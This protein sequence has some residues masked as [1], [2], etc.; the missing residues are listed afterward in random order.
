MDAFKM[1]A[2]LVCVH[3]GSALMQKGVG[4]DGKTFYRP[5][6]GHIKLFEKSKNALM[7]EV[8]EEIH[9]ATRNVRLL[10]VVENIFTY[11]GKKAHEIV[12]LYYG[13]LAKKSLY[14]KRILERDEDGVKTFAYWIP[15]SDLEKAKSRVY[16]EGTYEQILKIASKR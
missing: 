9:T 10:G 4:D 1:K 8:N 6:G 3:N 16:P 7:R 2:Y 11:K 12:F 5:I 15:V 14:D 13:T